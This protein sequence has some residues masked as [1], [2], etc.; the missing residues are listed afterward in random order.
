MS[1]HHELDYPRIHSND[2]KGTIFIVLKI[3]NYTEQSLPHTKHSTHKVM[4]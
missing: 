1:E 3:I 4:V 2:L